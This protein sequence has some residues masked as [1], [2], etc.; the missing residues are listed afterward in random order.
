MRPPIA[1]MKIENVFSSWVAASQLYLYGLEGENEFG[2]ELVV[3]A[4]GGYRR[5]FE[6]EEIALIKAEKGQVLLFPFYRQEVTGVTRDSTAVKQGYSISTPGLPWHPDQ[7]VLVPLIQEAFRPAGWLAR[8]ATGMRSHLIHFCK[9]ILSEVLQ[10]LDAGGRLFPRFLHSPWEERVMREDK[11]GTLRAPNWCASPTRLQAASVP[12]GSVTAGHEGDSDA[13]QTVCLPVILT[14]DACVCWFLAGRNVIAS[15]ADSDKW[16][17]GAY[18]EWW[19]R[20]EHLDWQKQVLSESCEGVASQLEASQA[21]KEHQ[22]GGLWAASGASVCVSWG[23]RGS[24][25]T[26]QVLPSLSSYTRAPGHNL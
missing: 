14:C 3:Y 15:Q 22:A 20:L 23:G 1:K 25:G 9:G 21:W 4:T 19:N 12:R 18:S 5:V 17:C 11:R 10:L 2:R 6:A 16:W 24:L 7:P 13:L 8:W 26:V